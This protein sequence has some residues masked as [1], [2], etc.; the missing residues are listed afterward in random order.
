MIFITI[1]LYGNVLVSFPPSE[2]YYNLKPRVA[3]N[4]H[5]EN[6]LELVETT[7]QLLES[8]NYLYCADLLDA[9]R[10]IETTQLF[11]FSKA[12]IIECSG[13]FV[14]IFRALSVYL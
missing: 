7:F 13:R 11:G 1:L 8:S 3:V 14:C 5:C 6:Q 2:D 4:V 12:A 9:G 10:C